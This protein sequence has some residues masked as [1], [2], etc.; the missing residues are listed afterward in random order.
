MNQEIPYG[1]NSPDYPPESPKFVPQSPDTE[2]RALPNIPSPV[3]ANSPSTSP[4]FEEWYSKCNQN[5]H[6][7]VK[8]YVV[9]ENHL[10]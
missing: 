1:S 5:N 8:N 3:A 7:R 4:S 10:V 9:I 2:F 6:R